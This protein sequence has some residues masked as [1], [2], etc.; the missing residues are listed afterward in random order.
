MSQASEPVPRK[1]LRLWLGGAAVLLWLVRFGAPMLKPETILF[2][3]LGSLVGAVA[4][5][6]WWAFFSGV[7]VADRWG[8]VVLMIV[9]LF[10]TSRIIDKS[11]ATGMMGFMFIAYSIPV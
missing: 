9:A 7:P 2:G 5:L 4:I 1:P 6:V 10:A 3:M 8:A 11:I